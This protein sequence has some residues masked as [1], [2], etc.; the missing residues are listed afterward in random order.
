M[1]ATGPAPIYT[2]AAEDPDLVA[3]LEKL[4]RSIAVDELSFAP[5]LR[6]RCAAEPLAIRLI[7]EHEGIAPGCPAVLCPG[8][9]HAVSRL[10]DIAANCG[11]TVALGRNRQASDQTTADAEKTLPV[12]FHRMTS[13][14]LSGETPGLITFGRGASWQDL[15][16]ALDAAEKTDSCVPRGI[17]T[18]FAT[19]ADA[20]ASGTF[21]ARPAES[22]YGEACAW[23]MI[24]PAPGTLLLDGTWLFRSAEKA[25]NALAA[26]CRKVPPF[27]ARLIGE[28][29]LRIGEKIGLWRLPR[30]LTGGNTHIGLRLAYLGD[31]ITVRAQRFASTWPVEGHGGVFWRNGALLDDE[32]RIGLLLDNGLSEI[33]IPDDGNA[34][35]RLAQ[36]LGSDPAASDS[37]ADSGQH[38]AGAVPAT[39]A[40][41]SR[42]ARFDRGR[43]HYDLSAIVPRDFADPLGQWHRLAGAAIVKPEPQDSA[44]SEPDDEQRDTSA[45]RMTMPEQ[46]YDSIG[47]GGTAVSESAEWQA[48][49]AA[50]LPQ[51]E[52]AP[53]PPDL[54]ERAPARHG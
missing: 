21:S 16:D 14:Q 27:Q 30:R 45:D 7:R 18:L 44:P 25:E 52:A 48:I 9:A 12:S 51:G 54:E 17:S 39:P 1:L 37:G 28:A 35:D 8:D 38:D 50:L 15:R 4:D 26:V 41:I 5:D 13:V 47:N 42:K 22:V 29:E 10:V 32:E 11:L 23:E 43:L 2:T 36:V 40:I 53:P 34:A 24:L 19:P 6:Y 49:R 33:T 20:A 46:P 3:R 31:G